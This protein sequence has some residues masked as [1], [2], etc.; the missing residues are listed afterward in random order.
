MAQSGI[1]VIIVDGIIGAGKTSLINKCL[2][3][4]IES[5]GLKVWVVEEPVKLWREDGLLEMFYKDKKRRGFQFQVRAFHDRIV[6]A[7]KIK[8]NIA[9]GEMGVVI[10]ERSI[11]TDIIF[12]DCLKEL[13]NVDN[14]EYRDYL[15]LHS[16]WKE[17]FPFTPS[18]FLYLK[19]ELSEVMNRMRNRGRREESDVSFAYQEKLKKKHDDFFSNNDKPVIVID[20]YDFRYASEER[21]DMIEAILERCM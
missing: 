3:P 2:I 6:E 14:T 18:L 1:S 17:L 15:K 21:T 20:G 13:G 4:E 8:D 5:R 10:M 11:F 9:E 12:M 16:M 19:P 7:R